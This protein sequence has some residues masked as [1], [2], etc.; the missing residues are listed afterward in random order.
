MITRTELRSEEK[1]L[2]TFAVVC[3]TVCVCS[4]SSSSS[5]SADYFVADR[6]LGESA[7]TADSSP[8]FTASNA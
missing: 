8:L 1:D 6:L 3:L 2:T 7:E 5:P 4:S